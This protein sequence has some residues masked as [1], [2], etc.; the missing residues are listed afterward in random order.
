LKMI[1]TSAKAISD[2]VSAHEP[3]ESNVTIIAF[4]LVHHVT[5]H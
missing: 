5:V 2:S 4:S 1:D 3:L